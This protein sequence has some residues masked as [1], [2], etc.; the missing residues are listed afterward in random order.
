[1]RFLIDAQLPPSLAEKLVTL[2]HE[3]EHVNS[4]GMGAAK[5]RE[6]WAF[7]VERQ[8]VVVS[9]DQDFAGLAQKARKTTSVLWIRLGNTT[10]AAL[11][12][13][14]EPLLPEILEAFERGERLIEIT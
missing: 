14:L 5:D 7:A 13:A 3:A 2:G 9:K 4:I 11:W 1:M 6:I 8:A 12:R 10:G